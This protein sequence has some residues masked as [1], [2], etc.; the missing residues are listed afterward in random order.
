MNQNHN[1]MYKIYFYSLNTQTF[2]INSWRVYSPLIY[3]GLIFLKQIKVFREV[4]RNSQN[5]FLG[6]PF[7]KFF[8]LKISF[9]K[10]KDGDYI[11][12]GLS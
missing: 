12:D 3:G 4:G 10:S 1:S 2:K 9:K 7:L 6:T 8:P 11:L 5:W